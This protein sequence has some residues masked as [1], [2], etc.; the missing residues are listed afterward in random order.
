MQSFFDFRGYRTDL[1]GE[2]QHVDLLLIPSIAEPLGRVL[3]DA[4][5][6]EVP[7]V[8]SDA[9]G[10]GEIA[11]LYKVGIP[12]RSGNVASLVEAITHFSV[13]RESEIARFRRNSQQMLQSLSMKSYLANIEHI[14]HLTH[15]GKPCN[16]VWLGDE[17]PAYF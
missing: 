9:G 13:K 4:A 14:L 16:V 3:F 1:A 11:S 2:L 6:H 5:K 8:V 7:V 15:H 12:F 10:L 17:A